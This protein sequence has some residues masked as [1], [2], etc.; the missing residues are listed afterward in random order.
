MAFE[1]ISAAILTLCLIAPLLLIYHKY[2]Q[3]KK[4]KSRLIMQ[5]VAFFALGVVM[6]TMNM[7]HVLADAPAVELTAGLTDKAFGFIA[8]A[9]STGLSGI[10]GGI[11]VS[12]SAAAA[13]GAI[14]ENA[15]A[16]GKALI[17]VGLAE[18]IALYGMIIS[19]M[20]IGQF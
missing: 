19:F 15:N 8:A 1:L 12:S 5:I 9:L 3:G 7:T 20:I 17:F 13:L 4:V 14:S 10:G 16:F 6:V 11:A 2:V 18:G